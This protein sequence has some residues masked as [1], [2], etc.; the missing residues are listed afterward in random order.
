MN[1]KFNSVDEIL[2]Y[3]IG[4]EKE[5]ANSYSELAKKPLAE[6]ISLFSHGTAKRRIPA[7]PMR[8]RAFAAS[9]GRKE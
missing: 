5:A 4:K 2:D 6:D 9:F 3:A 8:L 7:L 1:I